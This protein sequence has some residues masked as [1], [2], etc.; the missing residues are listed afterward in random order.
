MLSPLG[1]RLKTSLE[2]P[3]R[4]MIIQPSLPPKQRSAKDYNRSHKCDFRS[5]KSLEPTPDGKQSRRRSS[6]AVK[7]SLP[8][9]FEHLCHVSFNS[10]YGAFKVSRNRP[11]ELTFPS[12]CSFWSMPCFNSMC[13][14]NFDRACDAESQRDYPKG[15]RGCYV[16]LPLMIVHGKD[17]WS[18]SVWS[19]STGLPLSF[20]P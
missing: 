2:L 7:I 12:S 16:S 6:R 4:P 9:D 14:S 5:L 10:E 8:K 18:L 1:I 11:F 13:D 17:E 19:S 20:E 15:A 3:R